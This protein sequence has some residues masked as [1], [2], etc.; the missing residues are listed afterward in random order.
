MHYRKL[1]LYRVLDGLPSAIFWAL[2]PKKTL[3]LGK[4]GLC[5]VFLVLH[6]TNKIY[7]AHFEAI[8]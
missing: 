6:S 2:V 3:A 7:K 4:E 1:A 5:R 8:N